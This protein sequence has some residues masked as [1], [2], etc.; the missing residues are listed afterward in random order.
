ML[1]KQFISKVSFMRSAWFVASLMLFLCLCIHPPVAPVKV[2]LHVEKTNGGQLNVSFSDTIVD[3]GSKIT[4]KA[5]PDTQMMFLGW[6]GSLQSTLDSVTFVV[7]GNM[8]VEARFRT[9]FREP[10]MIEIPSKNKIFLMGSNVSVAKSE[11]KPAHSVLFTYTYFLDKYEVTQSQYKLLMGTNPIETQGGDGVAIGDSFPVGNVSWYDAAL[12]CN[13]RSKAA[14]LDTVYAFTAQCKENQNCPYV[15]ENLEIHYERFGFRLPTEAEWEYACRAGSTTDFYWGANYPDISEADDYAWQSKNSN[16]IMHPIGLKKPNAF[17]LFDMAGNMAELVNDWLDSYHDSLS[18][19]PIGTVFN[20][21]QTSESN[22]ERPVR[23]GAWYLEEEHLRSSERKGPYPTPAGLYTSY[24]GFR[25]AVG[26]FFP[27]APAVSTQK[28]D[29]S[30]IQSCNLS[31]LLGFLGTL[32]VKCVFVKGPVGAKKLCYIDFSETGKPVHE[33]SD[34]VQPYCPVISPDGAYVAYS[35]QGEGGFSGASTVTIRSLHSPEKINRSSPSKPAFVPRWWVDQNTL[36]TYIVFPNNTVDNGRPAWKNPGK[37]FR[38]KIVD[39]TFV[40]EP[41]IICDTGSFNGGLSYDGVFLATGFTNAYMLNLKSNDLFDYFAPGKNGTSQ[42][43]QTCNVS[44]NPGYESQDE[45]MFLDFGCNSVSSIVGKSYNQ[46]SIIFTKTSSDS[47][48]WY[49]KPA[50][51]D[52]WENPEWSNNAQFAVARAQSDGEGEK[53]SIFCIDLASHAYLKL[54]EGLNIQEPFIWIS[55]ID[56]PQKQ[57]TNY[58]FAKY[59][60]PGGLSVGQLP[61]CM[62]L[63]LFWSQYQNLEC[64]AVGGS[65]MYYGL[66]PAKIIHVN[67]LNMATIASNPLTSSIIVSNYALSHISGLKIVIMGLDAYALDFNQEE[68]YLNGLPRTLGYMF[69]EANDFWKRGLPQ[70]IQEK[71]AAFDSTQWLSFLPNGCEKTMSAGDGWGDT[72]FKDS[73]GFQFEDS[74]IQFNIQLYS[75]FAKTLAAQNTHLLI[76]NFPENPKYK[77]TEKI[78]FGGPYRSVYAKLSA[79]LRE[80]EKQNPYFH[81]YDAN[82]GGDHDYTDA[83]AL[84][85][86]HLNYLGARK[87]S[88]RIDSLI[89]LYLGKN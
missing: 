17:G 13:A 20:L 57:D 66:D 47:I 25:C 69:D 70:K 35:S 75:D 32:S 14:G 44:I 76:V 6:F 15:L 77:Q 59:N 54:A 74:L 79:W 8:S 19:D 68:P 50:G 60:I 28:T 4:L 41:E 64:V 33:L 39:G 89:T 37:T 78:G 42:F 24:I 10:Q 30:S 71:I 46:H 38:Q 81:F 87:I 5:I 82:M 36:E 29:T 12:F 1:I 11:E 72:L 22:L 49:E 16:K 34:S 80:K 43:I 67:T 83:E 31:E 65:P 23:G 53:S 18:T 51:F 7:S 40:A 85:C 3:N 63:K 2:T 88:A 55:P 52:R 9:V 86:N 58:N 48:R 61:L 21:A 84:N 26:A 62:K 56:L 45:I 27:S 73:G